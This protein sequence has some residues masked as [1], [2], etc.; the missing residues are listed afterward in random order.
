MPLER[1][2]GMFRR[3]RLLSFL[4]ALLFIVLAGCG[5]KASSDAITLMKSVN[6][7]AA[8]LTTNTQTGINP[9]VVVLTDQNGKPVS[10]ALVSGTLDMP[11]MVMEGYPK[12]IKFNREE[13]GKY[14]GLL[15]VSM[16]GSWH[17]DLKII[18]PKGTVQDIPYVITFQVK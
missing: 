12:E 5:T 6:G 11:E 2:K 1:K 3:V 13:N 16:E 17:F 7:L 9:V 4:L 18:S 15:Q 14:S 10:D 8:T